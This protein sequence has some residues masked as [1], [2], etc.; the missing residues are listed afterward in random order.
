MEPVQAQ[1]VAV[2]NT[3]LQNRA[4]S[5]AVSVNSAPNERLTP[6]PQPARR[7]VG[8]A[9]YAGAKQWRRSAQP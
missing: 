4:T 6:T 3:R 5:A 7:S 8:R 1:Q 2:R 9:S